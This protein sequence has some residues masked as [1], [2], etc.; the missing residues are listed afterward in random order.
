MEVRSRDLVDP[1]VREAG[2]GEPDEI[3]I[4]TL[5]HVTNA[6]HDEDLVAAGT[7]GIWRLDDLT[8]TDHS[9]ELFSVSFIHAVEQGLLMSGHGQ[10]LLQ[11]LQGLDYVSDATVQAMHGEVFV[12]TTGELRRWPSQELLGQVDRP[13]DLVTIDD[14]VLVATRSGLKVLG[15]SFHITEGPPQALELVDHVLYVAEGTARVQTFDVSDPENPAWLGA[16]GVPGT[17]VDLSLDGQTLWIAVVDGVVGVDVSVPSEP[18]VKAFWPANEWAL[19]VHQ[20]ALMDWGW[21]HELELVGQGPVMGLSHRKVVADELVITNHGVGTLEVEVLGS[22]LGP[23]LLQADETM[24][25]SNGQEGPLCLVTNDPG[26]PV[27]ELEVRP[28][29]GLSLAVGEAAPELDLPGIDG[30]HHV[31]SDQLGQPVILVFFATWCPVCPPE[32]VDL[33]ALAAEWGATLWLVAPFDQPEAL[34]DFKEQLGIEVPILLDD[35]TA[36][37]AWRQA[38][39][40][41]QSLFPVIWVVGADGRITYADSSYEPDAIRAGLR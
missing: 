38:R 27:V 11:T 10:T 2:W 21:V 31:L 9:S 34:Q 13:V 1:A 24:T 6:T 3:D 30:E 41:D 25:L 15:G 37:D 36:Y 5:V 32:I 14:T 18:Q 29:E 16:F 7:G 35:G 19:G 8:L 17:A 26:Q 23:S 33:Q 22:S 4:S 20:D 40:F 12:T 39:A 28:G